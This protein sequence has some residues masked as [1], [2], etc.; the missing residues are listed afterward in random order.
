MTA[1]PTGVN[2]GAAHGVL[3]AWNKPCYENS[4]LWQWIPVPDEVDYM[5]RVLQTG[6]AVVAIAMIGACAPRVATLGNAPR[7]EQLVKLKPGL[8]KAQVRRTLGSPSSIAMFDK[9]TWYYISKRE[10]SYAFFKPSIK[11]QKVLI[12]RF[13]KVGTVKEIKSLGLADAREVKY[14][15]NETPTMGKEDGLITSMMRILLGQRSI[16]GGGGGAGGFGR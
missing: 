5:K 15:E 4:V 3:V 10:E 11:K 7:Q 13:D 1:G 2:F 8:S 16:F 6:A 9:N 14:V 12:V